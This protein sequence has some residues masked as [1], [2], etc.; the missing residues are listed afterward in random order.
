[1]KTILI[2]YDYDGVANWV[3]GVWKC[4]K[5]ETRAYKNFVEGFIKKGLKVTFQHVKGHSGIHENEE[6][7]RLAK[8]AVGIIKG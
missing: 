8:E 7:D 2:F 3:T 1:M 6:A 5:D 4:K